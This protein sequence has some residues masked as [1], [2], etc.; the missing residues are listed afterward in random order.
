MPGTCGLRPESANTCVLLLAF[1][2]SSGPCNCNGVKRLLEPTS[3]YVSSSPEKS[4]GSILDPKKHLFASSHRPSVMSSSLFRRTVQENF[5]LLIVASPAKAER[6]HDPTHA[7]H[8]NPFE[9]SD[10]NPL[11]SGQGSNPLLWTGQSCSDWVRMSRVGGSG[12]F[13]RSRRGQVQGFPR[14][15]P[16]TWWTTRP[17]RRSDHTRTWW[18]WTQLVRQN[19]CGHF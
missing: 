17:R 2:D 12:C 14:K 18:G 3:V 16:R 15:A 6:K 4:L 7:L 19:S 8:P 1:L 10:L 5:T 11:G 9:G 13:E